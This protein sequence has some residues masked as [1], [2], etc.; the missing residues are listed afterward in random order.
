[1]S[2]RVVAWLAVHLSLDTPSTWTT[3]RTVAVF[4]AFSIMAG[5][6]RDSPIGEDKL[7]I[8]MLGA[9][10]EVGRSCCVITFKGTLLVDS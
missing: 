6:E 9:G 5:D 10:Q 4:L 1:M 7:C 3:A 2:C 8:E